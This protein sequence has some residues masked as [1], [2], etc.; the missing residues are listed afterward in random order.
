MQSRYAGVP[1]VV[2]RRV[3]R[4]PMLHRTSGGLQH[5]GSGRE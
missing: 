1:G 5:T 2:N 3:V 4:T